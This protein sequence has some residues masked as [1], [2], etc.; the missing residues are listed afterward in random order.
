MK[1]QT[2]P[3]KPNVNLQDYKEVINSVLVFD[4][5]RYAQKKFE[6]MLK[7]YI[8]TFLNNIFEVNYKAYGGLPNI[9]L[10]NGEFIKKDVGTTF[11]LRD[12]E[13]VVELRGTPL[14]KYQN[15]QEII[16]KGEKDLEEFTNLLT[17][18]AMNT[19]TMNDFLK[20]VPECVDEF[21]ESKYKHITFNTEDKFNIEN[22]RLNVICTYW[23]ILNKL[24]G[25]KQ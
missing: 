16:K 5:I 19:E 11:T 20:Y 21:A 22:T 18:I 17:L 25:I 3:R 9:V 2:Y 14:E 4:Y 15:L 7:V 23:D 12:L 8:D 24:I 13:K 6:K 1:K 10:Y